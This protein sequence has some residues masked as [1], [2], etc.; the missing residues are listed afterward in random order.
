MSGV[1]TWKRLLRARNPS[2]LNADRRHQGVGVNGDLRGECR[3]KQLTHRSDWTGWLSGWLL[4][5]LPPR[6][7][8]T[9]TPGY[10]RPLQLAQLY[11]QIRICTTPSFITCNLFQVLWHG[12]SK[13]WCKNINMIFFLFWLCEKRL[14]IR[15]LVWLDRIISVLYGVKYL[16]L[17]QI[18]L[19]CMTSWN[20][21]FCL[22]VDQCWNKNPTLL[23]KQDQSC[24]GTKLWYMTQAPLIVFD[25]VIT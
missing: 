6:P 8:F 14:H 24:T 16:C 13:A 4:R 2:K 3:L 17:C 10:Y 11:Y 1:H 5:C 12:N 22:P 18:I 23:M 7:T 20:I 25:S 21:V 9:T 15:S 19:V